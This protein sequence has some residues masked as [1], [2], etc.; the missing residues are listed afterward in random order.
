M[1]AWEQVGYYS[2]YSLLIYMMLMYRTS[3]IIHKLYLYITVAYKQGTRSFHFRYIYC[4]IK[5][6]AVSKALP[7]SK[8]SFAENVLCGS[9][10]LAM[11]CCTLILLQSE[12]EHWFMCQHFRWNNFVNGFKICKVC[13]IK[14]PSKFSTVWYAHILLYRCWSW[15]YLFHSWSYESSPTCF[16]W[17]QQEHQ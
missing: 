11:G 13:E 12:H 4:L 14:D 16:P 17:T 6:T 9:D 1:F 15:V 5:L 10:S 8:L 3:N 7:T 2:M